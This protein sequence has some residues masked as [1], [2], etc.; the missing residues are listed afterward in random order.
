MNILR[1]SIAL[2]TFAAASA[3]AAGRTSQTALD[4][5]AVHADDLFFADCRG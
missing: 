4:S 3:H 1:L 5:I 2:L